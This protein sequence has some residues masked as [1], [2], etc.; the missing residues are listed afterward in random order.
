MLHEKLKAREMNSDVLLIRHVIM[1]PVSCIKVHFLFD[2]YT[3]PPPRLVRT[4][5]LHTATLRRFLCRIHT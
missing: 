5:A 2:P 1:T 4:L 3:T